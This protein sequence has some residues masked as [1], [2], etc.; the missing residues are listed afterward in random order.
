MVQAVLRTEVLCNSQLKRH[1]QI[2]RQESAVSQFILSESRELSVGV[3]QIK[4][5]DSR[6]SGDGSTPCHD[7]V[8]VFNSSYTVADC[9]EP[10]SPSC[11]RAVGTTTAARVKIPVHVGLGRRRKGLG[12]TRVPIPCS[13]VG[14]SNNC[15]CCQY[16][17]TITYQQ[18]PVLSYVPLVPVTDF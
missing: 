12:I 14:P 16:K 13:R 1:Q 15:G 4:T 11:A 8:R 17:K 18:E 3:R 2:C 6:F 10:V 5:M 9:A 7:R